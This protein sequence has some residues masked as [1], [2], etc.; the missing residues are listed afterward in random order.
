MK[1][2]Y[3]SQPAFTSF[4]HSAPPE[5]EKNI[6]LHL[7]RICQPE[8]LNLSGLLHYECRAIHIIIFNIFLL[9]IIQL[10]HL[11]SKQTLVLKTYQ[12]T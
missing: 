8:G 9:R 2:S 7:N 12:R 1:K 6:K 10:N 11:V 5:T 3:F 4:I